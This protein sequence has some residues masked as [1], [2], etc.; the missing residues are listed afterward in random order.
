VSFTSTITS[1]NKKKKRASDGARDVLILGDSTP[2]AKH[3]SDML[4]V[5]VVPSKAT[6]SACYMRQ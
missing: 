4:V 6:G 1:Y 2:I 5:A 3:E